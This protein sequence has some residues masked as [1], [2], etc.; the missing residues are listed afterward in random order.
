MNSQILNYICLGGIDIGYILI[1]M[2]AMIVLSFLLIIILM[3]KV[4]KWKKK[5]S[6]FMQGKDAKSLEQD[7]IGLYE[8]NK[9]VKI[10]IEKNK[11]NI[12]ELFKKHELSFQKFG[13]VKYDAFQQ[14]GGQLSFSLVLLNENDNGFIINSVHSTEGCYSYSKEIK[15]GECSISLGEEEKKALN[16]ALGINS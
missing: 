2:A 11:N 7:I 3:I 15:N 8:D 9:F 6:I 14:M 10:A 4:S 13:I 12:R 1:G 5:Y 16:I